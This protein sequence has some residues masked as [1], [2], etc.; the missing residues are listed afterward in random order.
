MRGKRVLRLFTG[1]VLEVVAFAFVGVKIVFGKLFSGS[2]SEFSR[3]GKL[4]VF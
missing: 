4:Q 3:F 1:V 2:E